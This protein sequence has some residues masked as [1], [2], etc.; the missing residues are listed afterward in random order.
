MLITW[1]NHQLSILTDL[2]KKDRPQNS[3]IGEKPS[4]NRKH[5]DR[6][7]WGGYGLCGKGTW[8][9]PG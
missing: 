5:Q 8:G 3:K 9:N 4:S 1:R 7:L 2:S 6:S